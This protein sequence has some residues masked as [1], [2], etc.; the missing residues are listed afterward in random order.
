MVSV[1]TRRRTGWWVVPWTAWC[2]AVRTTPPTSC[3]M[4]FKRV[5]S[6]MVCVR[7]RIRRI[8]MSGVLH[9]DSYLPRARRREGREAGAN[10]RAEAAEAEPVTGVAG[11][12]GYGTRQSI[13]LPRELDQK[14]D[15]QTP[16]FEDALMCYKV[17]YRTRTGLF[18]LQYRLGDGLCHR[19]IHCRTKSRMHI[20]IPFKIGNE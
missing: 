8:G 16:F 13:S 2:N 17:N 9:V 3:R 7:C 10:T 11:A 1:K 5:W 14:P 6:F 20:G 12:R 4:R 19:L 15:F 18:F